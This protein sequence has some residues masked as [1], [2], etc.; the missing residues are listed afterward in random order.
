MSGNPPVKLRDRHKLAY[1]W[2]PDGCQSVLDGGCAFGGGTVTLV[3][4]AAKVFGCDPNPEL[5]ARARK[6]YPQIPFELCP[7]EKMPYADASFE[8]VTMTDV[9]EHVGDEKLTSMN[10]FAF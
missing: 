3:G 7:L 10:S 5:I 2:L 8:A 4:K 6:T 1:D 9:F